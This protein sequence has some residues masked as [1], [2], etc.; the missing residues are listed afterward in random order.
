[1]VTHASNMSSTPEAEAL[2]LRS[3]WTTEQIPGE[4]GLHKETLSRTKITWDAFQINTLRVG[5]VKWM[6]QREK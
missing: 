1:M 5:D 6:E 2:S 3:A 4:P